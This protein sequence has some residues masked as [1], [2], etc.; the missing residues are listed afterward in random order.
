M[1]HINGSAYKRYAAEGLGVIVLLALWLAAIGFSGFTVWHTVRDLLAGWLALF[2]GQCLAGERLTGRLWRG[3]YGIFLLWM[4]VFPLVL[5]ASADG[6]TMDFDAVSQYY[7]AALFWGILSALLFSLGRRHRLW[8]LPIAAA[9]GIVTFL[10]SLIAFSYAG[11]YFVFH[12]AFVADDM[13]PVVQTTIRE[14]T[15]FLLLHGSAVLWLAGAAALLAYGLALGALAW[16]AMGGED[17]GARWKWK[18][19]VVLLVCVLLGAQLSANAKDG[20][21]FV[22]Y[23]QAKAFIESVKAAQAAHEENLKGFHLDGDAKALLSQK[24]PGT[25]LLI[26]GESE[27]S[28]HMSAFSP[29]HEGMTTPWLSAQGEADGF[30][31]FP[32]S[33]S[34]FPQTV[35]ALGM[36]LT[37]VNQ[38][39]G[40][41][42][43]EAL[44]ILDVAKEAGYTTWWLSNQDKIGNYDSPS[45]MVSGWADEERWTSP[46]MGDDKELLRFLQEIP[47]EGNHFVVL[48]IMGSHTRYAERVP[49]DFPPV[50]VAGHEAQEN[51]YDT[52]VAYTDE[53]LKE[54]FEYARDHM[55]LQSMLYCSDH[56]E[57]MKLGHGAGAFSFDMVRVPLFIYLSPAYQEIYPQTAAALAAH[58]ESVFTNDLVFD[59]VSGLLQAPSRE[60]EAQY[61]LSSPA[62]SLP[63]DKAV[64][65]HGAVK[66]AE[67]Q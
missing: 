58:K 24:L 35:Q 56:G 53:V 1:R 51:E 9:H 15:G 20:F 61:D 62:Y 40:R 17:A 59:T 31:L 27:T 57:D 65:K 25:V 29:A 49:K 50:Q 48:W 8:R 41:Q 34:N 66:I 23:R 10:F 37:G 16:H 32:R 33:Y 39:N 45:V 63:P 14:A 36:Y 30:Y 19:P 5:S 4:L 26:I 38:Y 7:K 6:W 18:S 43:T 22:E 46:S 55:H 54:I 2:L 64:T 52:T 60:Y 13:L 11:Y 67:D 42:L 3:S 12:T 47:T 44:S 21:P 28:V